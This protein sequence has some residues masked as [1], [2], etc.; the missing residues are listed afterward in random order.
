MRQFDVFKNPSQVSSKFAPFVIVLQ[1]SLTQTKSTVVVAPLVLP[2]RLPDRSRLFP[3][4]VIGK[5][6]FVM[7]TNELG[8][9][10]ISRLKEYVTNLVA[11]RTRV[12]AAIDMQFSGF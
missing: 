6:E 8:A 3:A 10:S 2:S 5:K 4:V 1:S 9:I 7:S 12:I 11:E